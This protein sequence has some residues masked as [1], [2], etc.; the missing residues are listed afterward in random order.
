MR[1]DL[2]YTE[3]REPLNFSK[4]TLLQSFKALP[5]SNDIVFLIME[6]DSLFN[7]PAWTIMNS[8]RR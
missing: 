8:K 3:M 2:L 1:N 5:V 7:V 4:S 6:S